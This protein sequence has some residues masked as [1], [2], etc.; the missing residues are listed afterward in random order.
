MQQISFENKLKGYKTAVVPTMGYLHEGHLS[1]IKRGKELADIVITTLFVNPTQF[2][3]NEDFNKYPRD[4]DRDFQLCKDYGC[5]YIFFPEVADMY[6]KGFNTSIHI[7]GITDK[8]EGE[9]RPTHFQGVATIV[10]KLFNATKPDFAIFGQK[11]YQQTLLLKRLAIDLDFGIEIDVAPTVRE[12]DG[13]AMSS[14]NTYLTPDLRSKATVLFFAL[15]EVKKMISTGETTRK[16]INST[17]LVTLKS[18]PEVKIDYAASALA[19]SLEEPEH[20]FPGDEIVVL[21]ALYLGK[22]RL[23]D[24]AVIKIPYRLNEENFIKT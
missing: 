8:F 13:L 16:T 23:I 15:E 4:Y 17:L 6:P 11:D 22:T 10:A 1:L 12:I 3:P 5:D 7:S 2:A 18:V 14:R 20:F 21:I 24:N 19:S 9:F